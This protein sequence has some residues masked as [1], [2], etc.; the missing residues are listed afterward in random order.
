MAKREAEPLSELNGSAGTTSHPAVEAQPHEGRH[1]NLHVIV[2][3]PAPAPVKKR[4]IGRNLVLLALFAGAAV[5]AG[6]AGYAW[7]TDGRFMVETDDAYVAADITTL[8]ANATGYVIDVKVH[9]NQAVKA[10]D[11][12]LRLD[13]GDYRITLRQAE[14]AF[15]SN[16]AT[17]DRISRQIASGKAQVTQAEAQVAAA[18]AKLTAA[19]AD[20]DRKTQLVSSAVSSQS[21]LDDARAN[22]DAASASLDAAKAAVDV[23]RA[24]VDVLVAQRVESERTGE[25]LAA[26]VAKAQRD[27][28]FTEIRAPVD[29]V[30]GNTTFKLGSYVTPGETLGSLVALDTA[31]IDAN[32]KETQ[33]ADLRPG[34]KV[35]I[36]VDAFDGHTAIE[37]TVESLSPATGSVFSLLPA[38]NATGNFTKVVQRVP[39]RISIPHDVAA[40]GRLRPGM[41]VVVAA[42]SRTAPQG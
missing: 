42:D 3:T 11:V 2:D 10:G 21:Q 19:E 36:D 1:S 24:N 31:H 14:A 28:T 39:V 9:D 8:A 29:G 25:T 41:S 13:D 18:A 6:R 15:A 4:K 38:N 27:L 30:V 23:A 5:F 37:G 40:S 32:Y 17:V 34:E 16:T 12:L 35:K 26:N 22:R 33:V 7:W 20:F